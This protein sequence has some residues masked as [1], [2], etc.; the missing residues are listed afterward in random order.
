MGAQISKRQLHLLDFII[1]EYIHS[2]KPVSSGVVAKKTDF[3]LSPATIRNDMVDLEEAG[4]ITQLHT[5]GGRVPTDKAY[6]YFVNSILSAGPI[7][8]LNS[9]RTAIESALLKAHG[10]EREITKSLAEVLSNLTDKLVITGTSEK[11]DFFKR[12][13]SSLFEEPEFQELDR[14]FQLTSFFDQF[15]LMFDRMEE[16]MFGRRPSTLKIY[17]G[18][19]NPF[20][21]MKEEA[22][23]VAT[24]PLPHRNT[25][26]ITLIG[27]MRM[28]YEKNIGV[29]THALK[30][31]Q[32]IA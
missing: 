2:A 30:M 28:D 26:S 20:P 7:R 8:I 10:D 18:Q 3:D 23:M 19:E 11:N 25:G 24:Y 22:M 16:E 27:P 12:G 9:D 5:S 31:I 21:E 6:R 32:N 29:I 14:I 15:D 13:L 17:I 1:R 4:L